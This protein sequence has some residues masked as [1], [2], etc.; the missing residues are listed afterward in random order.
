[1]INENTLNFIRFSSGFNNLKKEELETFAE[2]EIFEL[3]E[4]NASEEKQRK[5]FYTLL[6]STDG[7]QGV[8]QEDGKYTHTAW[9][10]SSDGTDR[11][12]TVYPNLN[13]LTNTKI[14]QGD[15]D[16]KI[17]VPVGA[18]SLSVSSNN[19]IKVINNGGVVGSPGGFSYTK[20]TNVNVGDTITLSCYIK[21]TG[22]V[23]I[24]NFSISIA[25]YG[26]SR[27]Y[28]TKDN[29]VIPNDGKPHF[30][31]LTTIVPGGS[32]VA[33]PRWFDVATA[34]NEK[35]I[36]EVDE[37][38][39]ESGSIATP[40]MPSA[41]EVTTADWPSYIGQYTDYT[42][43]DSINPSSY[44]WREIQG[45]YFYTLEDVN[46]NGTLKSYII[47]CLKLSLQ[48]RWGNNLEYHI[49]RKTKYLN[50]LTGMQV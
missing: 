28:P 15:I 31:S 19:G 10:Y 40:W 34:V 44:T 46:T 4:Y 37:M 27:S 45:K 29:L 1:M 41:S 33:I 23:D 22:T 21:N 38:K 9:S 17:W 30:F 32:D 8:E 12:S 6:Q 13:L 18:S 26:T 36:F 35:H 14:T 49:D 16:S 7:T 39:L 50:K 3:N 5:H 2:N 25:F 48:T 42:L 43:E 47:E 24:K 11:F 20:T